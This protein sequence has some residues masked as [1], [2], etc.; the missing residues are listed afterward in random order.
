MVTPI[1]MANLK[2]MAYARYASRTSLTLAGR[3]PPSSAAL[4]LLKL[5]ATAVTATAALVVLLLGIEDDRASSMSASLFGDA[6]IT[7]A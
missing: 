1:H 5:F 3:P 7:L 4:V 6:A 2:L